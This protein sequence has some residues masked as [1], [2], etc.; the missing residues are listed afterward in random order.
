MATDW[1]ALIGVDNAK[2]VCNKNRIPFDEMGGYCV[3]P[4]SRLEM[5]TK[6][7]QTELD[8]SQDIGMARF[9][10]VVLKP[11]GRREKQKQRRS[12]REGMPASDRATME[13]FI[14]YCS[15]GYAKQ[16]QELL[17]EKETA[18]KQVA[19]A[20]TAMIEAARAQEAITQQIAE[21][22]QRGLRVLYEEDLEIEFNSIAK[23][24][25]V[26]K[27]EFAGKGDDGELVITTGTIR[28]RG[29]GELGTFEIHIGLNPQGIRHD[30]YGI[31]KVKIKPLKMVGSH[32]HYSPHYVDQSEYCD[33]FCL[34]TY[35]EGIV[36]A[37][38]QF[39]L[40]V[41]FDVILR[42]LEEG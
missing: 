36:Q 37:L 19:D 27:V 5:F 26:K 10:G 34:G 15:Q 18:D 25:K 38:K 16:A 29:Q 1:V 14:D 31:N 40:S 35:G 23:S 39:K 20:T 4:R 24:P 17:K 6:L 12:E 32:V 33:G 2:D 41:A 11:I 22:E 28:N 21:M 9:E 3:I 30:H 7:T 13:R 42:Y 8:G